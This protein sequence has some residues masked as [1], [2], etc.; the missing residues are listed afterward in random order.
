MVIAVWQG[1]TKPLVNEYIMRFVKELKDIL[2]AGIIITSKYIKVRFGAIICDTPARSLLKGLIKVKVFLCAFKPWLKIK[3]N[4]I[5]TFRNS[6]F[7]P[8][9]RMPKMYS[10]RII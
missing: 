10:P 7:Q 1:E 2:H 8:Q 3:K 5:S 4:Y 9:T 6:Q